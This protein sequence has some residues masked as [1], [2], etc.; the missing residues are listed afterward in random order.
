MAWKSA[1]VSAAAWKSKYGHREN[2]I[3]G[4]ARRQASALKA[5]MRRGA[6]SVGEQPRNATRNIK[7]ILQ[8]NPNSR[9]ASQSAGSKKS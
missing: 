2:L 4:H 5:A 1:A 7:P 6:S 9:M 3:R 8:T